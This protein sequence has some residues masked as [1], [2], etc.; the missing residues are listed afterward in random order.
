MYPYFEDYNGYQVSPTQGKAAGMWWPPTPS[1]C[2]GQVWVKLYLYL[3]SL[4]IWHVTEQVFHF[5]F[6]LQNQNNFSTRNY[7]CSIPCVCV[8][9]MFETTVKPS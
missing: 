3:P 8:T 2:W 6:T 1:W 9:S 5:T 7:Q 4:P